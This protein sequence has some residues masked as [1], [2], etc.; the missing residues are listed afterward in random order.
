MCLLR[1]REAALDMIDQRRPRRV[2]IV[3][4]DPT[5]PIIPSSISA[6]ARRP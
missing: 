5:R 6:A 2:P 1:M 4:R 3:S